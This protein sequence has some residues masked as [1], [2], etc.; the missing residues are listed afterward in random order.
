[1]I[2]Q[3]VNVDPASASERGVGTPHEIPKARAGRVVRVE[4]QVSPKKAGVLVEFRLEAGGSNLEP[5]VAAENLTGAERA[6]LAQ[7]RKLLPGLQNPGVLKRKAATDAEGKAAVDIFVSGFG[8]DTF[9]VKA[10]IVKPDGGKGGELGEVELEVW[11][12]FYADT[13]RLDAAKV[14]PGRSGGVLPAVSALDPALV[15]SELEKLGI[16]MVDDSQCAVIPRV[17]N[18]M[19]SNVDA[20]FGATAR[21]KYQERR[22][23]VGVRV[24]HVFDITKP[25]EA[26][27][28]RPFK[29][30]KAPDAKLR[31]PTP[32]PL[33]RDQSKPHRT[34]WLL[35]A[36]VYDPKVRGPD[37]KRVLRRV[38]DRCVT[39]KGPQLLEAEL[40]AFV[41]RE[42]LD[43]QALVLVV[44][45]VEVAGSYNG[46]Q[47]GRAVW[48]ASHYTQGADRPAR[49]R[50]GT[51]VH[52]LGHYVELTSPLQK[53]HYTGRDHQ[54]PH[55]NEGLS[56]VDKAKQHYAGLGGSCV[57]FG[58]GHAAR[59]T[60]FCA[61]CAKAGKRSTVRRAGANP[62]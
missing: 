34:D 5:G 15:V 12:R 7:I 36:A 39:A 59:S 28:R 54:G 43:G 55:C 37:G 22:G 30:S 21:A 19:R 58:E 35:W 53:T 8:K 48:V 50:Q 51:L 9:K 62:W 23:A 61:E 3:Y 33:Y 14:A 26:Y 20:D 46:M 11:K 45:Y 42:G 16:E 24:V 17:L 31:V 41:D 6:Q 40:G 1:M 32:S 27:L 52:E 13:A 60:S 49:D 38:P 18:V 10:A 57:L 47:W 2:R 25:A 44:K 56:A 29:A 4:A